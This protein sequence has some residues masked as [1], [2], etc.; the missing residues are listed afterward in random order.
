MTGR[1]KCYAF[2][3]QLRAAQDEDIVVDADGQ[4]KVR[5]QMLEQPT[6]LS[7]QVDSAAIFHFHNEDHTLGNPLRHVLLSNEEVIAAGYVIPHP[8]EPF[9]KLQVQAKK[10]DDRHNFAVDQVVNA[11]DKLADICDGTREAFV[12]AMEKFD[13]A[14]TRVD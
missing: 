14:K 6:D 2:Q 11:L 12:S 5:I 4:Q 3:Q 9:M 13:K 1:D 7:S 8:L 10:S